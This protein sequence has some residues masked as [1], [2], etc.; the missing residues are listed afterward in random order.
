MQGSLS[1]GAYQISKSHPDV[2]GDFS[3]LNSGG[4]HLTRCF[5]NKLD[6]VKAHIDLKNSTC[7]VN[8]EITREKEYS[9]WDSLLPLIT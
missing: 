7:A 4:H 2:D 6:R 5:D 9:S 1:N 3:P 8:S